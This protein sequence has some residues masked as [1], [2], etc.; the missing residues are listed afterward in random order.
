MNTWHDLMVT[1][2]VDF[3]AGVKL[4]FWTP[5]SILSETSVLTVYPIIFSKKKTQVAARHT[6]RI[7]NYFGPILAVALE[8]Q[9]PT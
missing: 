1:P 7:I 3:S 9:E 8:R 6:F 5:L 2:N 4:F